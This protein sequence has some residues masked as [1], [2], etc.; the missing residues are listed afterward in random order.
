MSVWLTLFAIN[1]YLKDELSYK[2]K[3]GWEEYKN[4]SY[5]LLPKLFKSDIVNLAI[6]F[7]LVLIVYNYYQECC[8][9][10]GHHHGHDHGHHMHGQI[11]GTHAH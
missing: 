2:K 4:N 8:D 6:Y 1:I 7:G 11:N 9:G 3:A 5:I 10:H